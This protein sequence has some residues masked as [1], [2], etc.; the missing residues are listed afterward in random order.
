MINLFENYNQE[1]QEL[2]QSLKRAG[3]NHFTIVIND[4]G[5]LPDDVT[6]PYRFFAAYQIYEDDTPAF[7]ND[8]DT[9]P[10]WEIKGDA[11]M[12]TITDM[13]ELRGE[14]FYKEHYK[15]RVVRHVEWLDSKQRLR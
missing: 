14:I 3:Y 10:F 13:G 2:H 1:T 8:I 4:D 15:T 11:T 9:P 6:S 7:F 5:F 12:A